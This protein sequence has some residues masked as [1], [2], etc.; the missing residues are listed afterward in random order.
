MSGT[1]VLSCFPR[2]ALGNHKE[3]ESSVLS[4][5][6]SRVGKEGRRAVTRVRKGKNGLC[7]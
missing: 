3:T 6:P 4:F 7:V 1:C 2:I 5:P